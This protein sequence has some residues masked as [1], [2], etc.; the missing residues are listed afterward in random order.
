MKTGADEKEKSRAAGR[1]ILL[2]FLLFF[3]GV[4]AVNII[5]VYKAT[6]THTGTVI[7]QPYERGLEYNKTLTAATAQAGFSW[8]VDVQMKKVAALEYELTFIAGDRR[9]NTVPLDGFD[10]LVLRPVNASDDLHP[11]FKA[12]TPGKYTGHVIFP[13]PGRWEIKVKAVRGAETFYL[14]KPLVIE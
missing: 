6:E 5:F 10:I 2:A 1:N 7:D 11:E 9:G 3:L 8:G 13:K 14:T 4:A 12:E